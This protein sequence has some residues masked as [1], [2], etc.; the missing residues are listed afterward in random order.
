PAGPG[1]DAPAPGGG[2]GASPARTGRR[3]RRT[4]PGPPARG[5]A[6]RGGRAPPARALSWADCTGGPD[7]PRRPIGRCPAVSSRLL[8]SET[9][10]PAS[11]GAMSASEW[12]VVSAVGL[13]VCLGSLGL[14]WGGGGLYTARRAPATPTRSGPSYGWIVVAFAAW[15]VVRAVPEGDWGS[16]TLGATWVRAPG[17]IVLFASTAFTLWARVVL[18]TMWSSS[19]VAKEGH[20][21]RTDGPYAVT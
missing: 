21:L 1:G 7:A 6:G 2:P 3:P 20:Q 17:L 14:L 15:L 16:L 11:R 12:H 13:G 19:A 10:L 9:S 18:G 4:A 5:R 8:S